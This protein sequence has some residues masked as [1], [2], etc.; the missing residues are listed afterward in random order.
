MMQTP[1]P[2]IDAHAQCGIKWHRHPDESVYA[3]DAARCRKALAGAGLWELENVWADTALAGPG[4]IC[5]YI[6]SY[7]HRRLMFGSD[8]PFGDP[9]Q[10]MKKICRLRLAPGV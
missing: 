5:R 7:G 8:F 3:Y 4:E 1:P 9:F 2:V 10:E 6:Q